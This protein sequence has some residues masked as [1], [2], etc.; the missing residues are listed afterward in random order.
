MYEHGEYKGPF[1]YV[2]HSYFHGW[3]TETGD[4]A[5]A[6]RIIS[7]PKDGTVTGK[8][9]EWGLD[10]PTIHRKGAEIQTNLLMGQ[11]EKAKL[12]SKKWWRRGDSNPLTPCL[13]SIG[14]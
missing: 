2:V 14:A 12:A 7:C 3:S 9:V 11:E 6:R 10:Q 13:Q 8:F 5:E 1:W 4:S